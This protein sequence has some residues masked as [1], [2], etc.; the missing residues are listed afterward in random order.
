VTTQFF[1][2]WEH[3]YGRQIEPE[4]GDKVILSLE[5]FPEDRRYLD[6]PVIGESTFS[7]STQQNTDSGQPSPLFKLCAESSASGTFQ[8]FVRI[9]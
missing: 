4:K 8:M 3:G 9:L 2:L 6:Y 1:K 7:L 5:P